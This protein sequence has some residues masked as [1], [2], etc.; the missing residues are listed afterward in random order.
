MFD[1]ATDAAKPR[2]LGC[3]LD[4]ECR[5][6]GGVDGGGGREKGSMVSGVGD[7]REGG[8]TPG[9]G[10]ARRGCNV[11]WFVMCGCDYLII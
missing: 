3:A 4:K 5:R 11:G 10:R 2:F 9:V 1:Q 8:V 6:V 7:T